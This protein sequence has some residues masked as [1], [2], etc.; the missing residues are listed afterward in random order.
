MRDYAK[1]KPTESSHI[2]VITPELLA[3]NGW[4]KDGFCW[5]SPHKRVS[6]QFITIDNELYYYLW[7]YGDSRN[8]CR[9]S[10]AKAVLGF[11]RGYGLELQPLTYV[12]VLKSE[13]F[14]EVDGALQK[15]SK[16]G[17]VNIEDDYADDLLLIKHYQSGNLL[18]APK[19]NPAKILQAVNFLEEFA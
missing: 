9:T 11:L 13:G 16:S 2:E 6:S 3:A 1:E 17:T 5:I 7:L 12:D 4:V 19:D 14:I 8:I 15:V 18:V 10:E